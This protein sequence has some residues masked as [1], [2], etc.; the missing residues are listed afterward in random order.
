M[1]PSEYISL[2]SSEDV[3]NIARRSATTYLNLP[4]GRPVQ[5]FSASVRAGV[6]ESVMTN[7]SQ[8]VAGYTAHQVV[9]GLNAYI[10]TFWG[11][12]LLTYTSGGGIE[13]VGMARAVNEML[14]AS[15]GGVLRLFPGWP[16]DEPA[17]FVTLRAKGGL[18]VS[19]SYTCASAVNNGSIE[20]VRITSTEGGP[21]RVLDPWP[22][23]SYEA[24]NTWHSV[25][26][27][28]DAAGNG[29]VVTWSNTVDSR[30]HFVLVFQSDPGVEYTLERI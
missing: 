19:A 20:G 4:K 29:V 18:L 11:P 28:H 30:G 22:S 23:P 7:G 8:V 10:D 24:R 25:V 3:L 15:D 17:S 21:C 27:V 1:F 12:N 9:D 5:T 13:N 16:S 6:R 26:G 2:A 14:V